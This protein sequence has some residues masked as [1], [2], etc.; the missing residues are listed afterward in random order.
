MELCHMHMLR[1]FQVFNKFQS[2][3]LMEFIL[4]KELS[5]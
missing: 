4:V 5:K 2:F 3:K 1:H